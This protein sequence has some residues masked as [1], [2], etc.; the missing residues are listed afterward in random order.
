MTS[1][2]FSGFLVFIVQQFNNRMYMDKCYMGMFVILAGYSVYNWFFNIVKES[3]FQGHHTFKVTQGLR[4]GMVLF[5]L[6][7]VMFFFSFFWAFFHSALAPTTA[8]GCVWP[9]VNTEVLDP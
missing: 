9:P 2:A 4:Y 5:I 8:I 3:T 6:S 7:E 1:I